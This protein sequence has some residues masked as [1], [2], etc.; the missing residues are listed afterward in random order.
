MKRSTAVST[1]LVTALVFSAPVI[2]AKAESQAAEDFEII[3]SC[4]NGTWDDSD[5]IGDKNSVYICNCI[6][7]SRRYYDTYY[8]FPDCYGKNTVVKLTN[9][10][11]TEELL[12]W[13]AEYDWKDITTDEGVISPRENAFYIYDDNGD[14]TEGFVVLYPGMLIR[15]SIYNYY[16]EDSPVDKIVDELNGYL[17][18]L[19]SEKAA[20]LSAGDINADGTVNVTDISMLAAQV[21]SVRPLNKADNAMIDQ[22]KRADLNDDG[23]VD[24]SDIAKLAAK[25]KGINIK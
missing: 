23:A 22:T 18:K 20:E 5:I 12:K 21:K 15:S 13:C 11:L 25:V 7:P 24:V 16:G 2:S 19:D 9:K 8:D 1:A 17:D 14:E 10:E 4:G 3:K 6:D